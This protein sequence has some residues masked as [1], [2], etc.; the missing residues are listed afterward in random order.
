MHYALARTKNPRGDTETP[1]VERGR[2]KRE[3]MVENRGAQGK[4]NLERVP[5]RSYDER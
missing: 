5:S 3:R 2:R 4:R 1:G